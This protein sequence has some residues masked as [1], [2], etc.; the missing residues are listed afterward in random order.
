MILNIV[1]ITPS[2]LFRV[3]GYIKKMEYVCLDTETSNGK[4]VMLQLGDTEQQFIL[5]CIKYPDLAVTI[6]RHTIEKTVVGHNLSYDY[7]VI[8]N[9]FNIKLKAMWDTMVAAQIL[10]CG[11]PSPKGHF[12]LA[13]T[14]NRYVDPYAYS[15]QLYLGLPYITKKQRDT[16]ANTYPFTEEQLIYAALDVYYTYGLFTKLVS[17]LEKEKLTK[18]AELE[19]EF[20]GAVCS[21]QYNGIRLDVKKWEELAAVSSEK[22]NEALEKLREIADINWNSPVQV[23]KVFKS[24]GISTSVWDKETGTVKNSVS[25]TALQANHPVAELYLKY[26]ELAKASSSYGISFLKHLRPDGTITTTYRQILNTGRTASSSPNLQNIPHEEEYRRCFIAE[27]GKKLVSAD[28][29]N[30]EARLA[31]S[32]SGDSTLK[33][34]F[35]SGEDFH[36]ATARKIYDRE[37]IDKNSEERRTAKTVNFAI[38]YGGGVSTLVS[39]SKLTTAKAKQII[40][41]YFT[42]FSRLAEYF[43]EQFDLALQQGYIVIDDGPTFRKSYIPFYKELLFLLSVS[44]LNYPSYEIRLSKLLSE[45]DRMSKNYRIQGTGANIAKLACIHVEKYLN[46]IGGKLLLLVHDELVFEV[47]EE[48]AT[49]AAKT[50]KLIMEW[51]ASQYSTVPIPVDYKINNYWEH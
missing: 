5:D 31:A 41:S 43:K 27:E 42:T 21:M 33:A 36:T 4:V 1:D 12:T 8:R 10:E 6:L 23:S 13:Q 32:L 37:D 30:M 26:K 15:S 11:L 49:Q 38:I 39:R 16:F 9:T 50:V 29:S 44:H 25:R 20:L 35:E 3:L 47:P 51:A 28:F 19:M 18:T 22:A 34:I 2:T 7:T 48:M 46:T 24:L 45:L 14:V 17:K 40:N